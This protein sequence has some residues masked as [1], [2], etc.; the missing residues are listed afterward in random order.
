MHAGPQ[1]IRMAAALSLRRSPWYVTEFYLQDSRHYESLQILTDA[2]LTAGF[3]QAW[4]DYCTND[5]QT[6]AEMPSYT[7]LR[8]ILHAS[9]N[10]AAATVVGAEE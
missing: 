1:G 3:L 5:L 8:A 10:E 9:Q 7:R 6:A 2:C 4:H